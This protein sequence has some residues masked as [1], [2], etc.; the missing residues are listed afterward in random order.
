MAK[1]DLYDPKWIEMVFANKNREYGAYKL[2]KGTSNRNIKALLI[3]AIAAT[4]VG[5]FLVYKIQAQ[6]AEEARMARMEA[7]ELSKLQEQAKKRE[8]KEI[9]K[10]KIQPK[11]EIPVARQTQKFT[12]PVI[13]KDELVKEENQVKQMDKLDEKVAVGTENVKG[14][15]NRTVEA[16]RNDIAVNTPP[17]APKQ[18]VTQKVFDVVEEMPSYPGG[19]AA[20]MSYLNS[21]IRYPVVAQEN[22]VQGRVVI[23]FVVETD[24][25]ITQVKVAR[26]VDPSLD[27][28]AE[29]V[30][31]AMPHWKPGRQ[32]GQ[33]VRVKY[34]VPVTFKL[35]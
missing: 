28:E 19:P 4:L 6:K 12:A 8:K 13:K 10:P 25:S 35:Q 2:R 11:K 9:V 24:G 14:T 5:G 21:N 20:L 30:V 32:N 1:I 34:N 31:S 7:M 22:G 17:P 15:T 23:S 27:K 33:A 16:V 3:L 29:R 18:E 26:S